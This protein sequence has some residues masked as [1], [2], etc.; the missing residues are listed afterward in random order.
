MGEVSE[1]SACLGATVVYSTT[2]AVEWA[3]IAAIL[4]STRSIKR[5][6]SGVVERHV[7]QRG[8]TACDGRAGGRRRGPGGRHSWS[9]ASALR[10]HRPRASRGPVCGGAVPARRK[11]RDRT[12]RVPSASAPTASGKQRGGAQHRRLRGVDHR[13]AEGGLDPRPGK[14]PSWRNEH[15]RAIDV[16]AASR[17]R[18]FG[19]SRDPRPANRARRDRA[20]GR[21]QGAV[22]DRAPR[23]HARYVR[24]P[25][26]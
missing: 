11:R 5:S 14:H 13:H 17:P 24:S 10:S 1:G 18:R 26:R 23:S 8:D 19:R 21:P 12:A 6:R 4:A 25:L 2:S 20:P 7:D 16:I 22:R 3:S 15:V 9:R